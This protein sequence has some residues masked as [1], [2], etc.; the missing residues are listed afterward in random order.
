M[1]KIATWTTLALAATLAGCT[2]SAHTNTSLESVHQPIVRNSIYQFDVATSGGELPPSEQ[3]RLQGWLDAMGVRYGDRIAIEDPSPYGSSLARSSIRAMV[4]RRG[5]LLSD[6]VPVTTGTVA[7]GGLRVVVTRATA[8]VP[9]CPD[10]S[11]KS[12]INFN[13]A[14]SSNYGCAMNSNLAAMVA[15]PNDLIKGTSADHQDPASSARAIKTYRERPPT[16]A[17]ELQGV[18]TTTKKGASQ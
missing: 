6:A 14:T 18:S 16:G 4:E 11:S 1:K 8:S 7:P 12:S 3:G 15:D 5:L 10:W 17:G 9:G 13:N 2:G